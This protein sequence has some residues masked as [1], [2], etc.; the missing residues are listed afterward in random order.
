MGNASKERRLQIL[1]FKINRMLSLIVLYYKYGISPRKIERIIIK[2]IKYLRQE[3]E[4]Y[5]QA[6]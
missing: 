5:H 1:R 2:L 6:S 4:V 3:D